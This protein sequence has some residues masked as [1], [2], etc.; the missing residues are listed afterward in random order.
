[1]QPVNEQISQLY[2][3]K[4]GSEPVSISK[5]PQ[6]GSDRIYYRVE[7]VQTCIATSNKTSKK[8]KP[9]SGSVRILK[10]AIAPFLKFLR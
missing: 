5:I 8:I 1:M 9:F 2:Q 3:T 7:G 4:F 10:K 6:S